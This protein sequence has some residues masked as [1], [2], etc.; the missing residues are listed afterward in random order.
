MTEPERSWSDVFSPVNMFECIHRRDAN[1]DIELRS[2]RE[3]LEKMR[4]LLNYK[5]DAPK[6]LSELREQ[7]LRKN[8]LLALLA[9]NSFFIGLLIGS[10]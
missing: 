5:Y 2:N 8:V 7:R 3:S 4:D 1:G 9:V 6:T 10:L